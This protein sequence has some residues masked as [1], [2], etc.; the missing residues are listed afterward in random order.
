VGDLSTSVQVSLLRVLQEGMI[1]RVGDERSTRVDV[2]VL[3][4]THKDLRKEVATGRF[5]EDL[6]YIDGGDDEEG[7]EAGEDEAA[8]D[9]DAKGLAAAAGATDGEG[10]GQDAEDCGE[11]G[12]QD[13]TEA[14][15]GGFERGLGLERPCSLRWL[16]NST[17]RMPF[18]VTRPMSMMMPIWLK[19]LRV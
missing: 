6:Y 19:T 11:A 17:M 9:G 3:S 18:F 2:R 10:D 8:D 16:A 1:D 14:R 15:D 13:G 5:R 4:A 12:H 7:E